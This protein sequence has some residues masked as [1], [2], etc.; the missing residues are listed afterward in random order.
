M[1]ILFQ[2]SAK[3]SIWTCSRK[4]TEEA[5]NIIILSADEE[6][7]TQN[8]TLSQGCKGQHSQDSDHVGVLSLTPQLGLPL[9]LMRPQA[10]AHPHPP[11]PL[12]CVYLHL[13]LQWVTASLPCL[14]PENS[15][16]G[17]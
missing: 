12:L 7:E 5:I 14:L 11:A 15:R 13:A 4:L 6:T 17:N 10:R 2:N 3:C 8:L 16:R 1:L 9:I